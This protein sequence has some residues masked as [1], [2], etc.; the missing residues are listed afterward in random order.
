M[1][2][3]K[4]S[5]WGSQTQAA[6]SSVGLRI[7]QLYTVFK[8][9]SH[10][11]LVQNINSSLE[12]NVNVLLNIPRTLIALAAALLHYRE[13]FI[14]ELVHIPRSFSNSTSL[15]SKRDLSTAL[16]VLPICITLHLSKLAWISARLQTDTACL[17]SIVMWKLCMI[18][19]Y[20][21]FPITVDF[22]LLI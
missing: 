13:D 18:I 12:L 17:D 7:V 21:Y 10:V 3:I 6:Y 22:K 16:R 14:E 19:S 9:K 20:V 11:S 8:K 15:N 5:W 2:Y 4:Y 1:S